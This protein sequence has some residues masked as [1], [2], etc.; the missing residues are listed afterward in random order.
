[1]LPMRNDTGTLPQ[2]HNRLQFDGGFSICMDQRCAKRR[3]F[4]AS[5][6]HGMSGCA[7]TVLLHQRFRATAPATVRS[8]SQ[9][10]AIQLPR[11]GLSVKFGLFRIAFSQWKPNP[12]VPD[13][14]ATAVLKRHCGCPS[15]PTMPFSIQHRCVSCAVGGGPQASDAVPHPWCPLSHEWFPNFAYE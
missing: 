13:I 4:V 15:S 1:M 2:K 3:T 5:R 7:F 6:K 10:L 11:M 14:C 8:L 12:D 9:V